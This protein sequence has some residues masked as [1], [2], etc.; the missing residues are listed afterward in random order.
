MKALIVGNGAREHAIAS[1]LPDCELYCIMSRKNPAMAALSR[2]SWIC[3]IEDPAAVGKCIAGRSFDLGFASPD[4]SLAA[5]ITDVLEKSGI[6]VASPSRAAARVEWDKS[7]MRSLMARH[8]IPGAPENALAKTPGEALSLMRK[9]GQVAIKPVGLTGGKGVRVSGDHFTAEEDGLAYAKS[10]ILKDG[11]ALMEEKLV[12]EEF[13]LQAFSDG[14]RIFVMPPVQDHKR[15]F[16]GEKG[17]NTGGMGSYSAGKNLPFL[18]SSD[19]ERA[20]DILR[21]VIGAL[22]K[23][24]SPFR[25][26]LYGQFMATASG[27]KVIEFNARFGDPEAMNVLS[28]L[29]SPLSGIFSA[30]AAGKLGSAK[31]SDDC[32]VVKYLVP[33][34]YPENPLRDAEVRLDHSRLRESGASAYY[35]SVYEK[36]G[37]IFTSSSRAFGI[38]GRAKSLDEAERIAESGCTALSGPLWH[39]RDIGT[40]AL[41]AA[42]VSRMRALRGEK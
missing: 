28:L 34:G 17:P 21:A 22:K 27:P 36:D 26:I 39:R 6:P 10:L 19:L 4:A 2:E 30:I 32:T 13:T 9:L 25:G 33:Q 15:A 20:S 37:K 16:E 35:A 3:D 12:G 14:T 38:L 31:F 29:E 7:F 8:K 41:I 40:S 23:E 11:V 1:R 42:K 5:G 18:E 24:G